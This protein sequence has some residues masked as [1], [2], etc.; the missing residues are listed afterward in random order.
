[1]KKRIR[2]I[3]NRCAITSVH[4]NSILQP[5]AFNNKTDNNYAIYEYNRLLQYFVLE[6]KKST[7]LHDFLTTKRLPKQPPKPSMNKR[8]KVI[9]A[10]TLK[11][12]IFFCSLLYIARKRHLILNNKKSVFISLLINIV[13]RNILNFFIN[14]TNTKSQSTLKTHDHIISEWLEHYI[15][16]INKSRIIMHRPDKG[17]DPGCLSDIDTNNNLSLT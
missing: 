9:L 11:W 12:A 15:I 6:Y 4:I 3:N 10:N 2:I 13:A 8:S 7:A 5:V 17:L 14:H 1:M 16:R